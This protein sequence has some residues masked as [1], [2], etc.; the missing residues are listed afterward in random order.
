MDSSLETVQLITNREAARVLFQIASLLETMECNPF[1]VRAYRRAA[2]A[3]LFLPQELSDY[4]CAGE[5]PPLDGVGDGLAAKIMDLVNTG[6][7]GVH[8][9]LMEEI[10][11]PMASLLSVEGIGPKTAV[12]LV[13]G[14]Q[15][16]TL[17]DV[18]A[19]AREHRIQSLRGFGEKRE[20]RIAE[21]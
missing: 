9:T 4:V 6:H 20:Q 8:E 13:S 7:M 12:R 18:A 17:D 11:E 15:V 16:A 10:G 19:A 21:A 14:L 3:V 1:R 5:V 2:L